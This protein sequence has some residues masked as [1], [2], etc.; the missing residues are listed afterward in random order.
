MALVDGGATDR[1]V[2]EL[3]LGLFDAKSANSRCPIPRVIPRCC[4]PGLKL[5]TRRDSVEMLKEILPG[6]AE[7]K[8]ALI[9]RINQ[10]R[11]RR[12]G[13]IESRCRTQRKAVP[14]WNNF[15]VR[16]CEGVK[17]AVGRMAAC[18]PAR[19]RVL[20]NGVRYATRWLTSRFAPQ[21]IRKENPHG[22]WQQ[23]AQQAR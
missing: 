14:P 16:Q 21:R 19:E 23:Y 5:P 22:L 8:D 17:I 3:Q 4:Q 7:G 6:K 1:S 11:Q 18:M 9:A 2:F 13:A 12:R 15:H 10:R 20:A